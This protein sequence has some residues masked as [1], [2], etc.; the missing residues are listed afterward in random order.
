MEVMLGNVKLMVKIE[1]NENFYCFAKQQHHKSHNSNGRK[2][3]F[4]P[5]LFSRT[6]S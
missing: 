2:C 4:F 5:H 6:T 3:C 1:T